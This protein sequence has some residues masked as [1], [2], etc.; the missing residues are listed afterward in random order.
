MSKKAWSPGRMIRSLNTCGCG[1]QRSPETALMLSTC[2]EPRSNRN[3]VTSATRSLSR[4]PGLSRSDEHLVG[5]VDHRAGGVEQHDLVDRL[6]LAGVEHHLLAVADDDPLGLER[7]DHRRL[8]DVDTER[9]VEHALGLA[10]S[11]RSRA[12]RAGTGRRRARPPRAARPSRRGCS[13][14]RATGQFRR[15]CLAA[16]PKSQ[17]CGRAA[18]RLERVAGH[19]VPRPLA[20]VGAGD[21]ADVVEVEQQERA[22][23]RG[24]RGRP[25]RARSGTTGAGRG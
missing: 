18:A 17:M 10:G 12:R 13:P 6:D 22:E 16:D 20:D 23:V 19:L 2:S 4:T 25:W 7:G 11:R 3:L 14:G 24:R 9:H 5:A 21:V 15:W 8:D 1:L